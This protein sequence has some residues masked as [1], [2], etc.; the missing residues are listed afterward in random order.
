MVRCKTTRGHREYVGEWK[1]KRQ[2]RKEE[3]GGT[4]CER[5]ERKVVTRED[6]TIGQLRGV[7]KHTWM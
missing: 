7:N 3:K 2:N 6:A 5:W 1:K 4:V